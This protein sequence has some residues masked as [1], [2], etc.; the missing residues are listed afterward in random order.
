M[1]DPLSKYR[2]KRDPQKT[3]EP[4]GGSASGTGSKPTF[5]IQEHHA[6]ALH[7]DFRLERDGV[8]V[9]WALPKGIPDFPTKNHLAV[10]TEDHPLEYAAFSGDIPEGEYGGGQVTLWDRGLYDT[11]KWSDREVMVVLHGERANG[12]YVLFR[13]SG[14]NWMIHRMDPASDG[15]EPIP[16]NLSLMKAVAGSLPAKDDGWAF[17]FLWDGIR[18]LLY[19]DGGRVRAIARNGRNLAPWFPEL[20]EIGASLGSKTAIL[21]GAITAFGDGGVPSFSHLQNRFNPRSP[22]R[23]PRLAREAPITFLAFDLLYLDG[24]LLSAMRYDERRNLL[25]SLE[26]TGRAYA[27]PPSVRDGD[28]DEIL[29]IA[30]DRGLLGVVAKRVQSQYAAGVR[31]EDWIK[32]SIFHTQKL[33]VGGWTGPDSGDLE[34]LLLGVPGEGGLA[35]AGDVSSGFTESDHLALRE[36]LEPLSQTDSPFQSRLPAT[37]GKDPHFIRP[38]LVVEVRY[39]SQT[40][41]GPL[42]DT[43]WRGIRPDVGP[44]QVTRR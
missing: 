30:C 15:T 39:R 6:R 37:A 4:M 1:P 43:S 20:R 35:F 27:C 40:S 26:L 42:R 13:T 31:S 25:E 36:A 3:P 7:W 8:L 5:V 44:D 29:R 24:R 23:V 41:E 33:V 32:T 18:A 22:S 16:E 28:G 12:R 21:D 34:S 10:H 17:E 9:S 2:S 38:D 11:E 19:V 14:K